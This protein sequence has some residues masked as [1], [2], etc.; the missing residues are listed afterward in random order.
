MPW[1]WPTASCCLHLHR[2]GM[3]ALMRCHRRHRCAALAVVAVV[4]M[5]WQ[6]PLVSRRH[7]LR[8]ASK[9]TLSPSG[10]C[11][12]RVVVV[13]PPHLCCAGVDVLMRCRRHR[14][15]VALVICVTLSSSPCLMP[16]VVVVPVSH[17]W[18][19]RPIKGTNVD[20]DVSSSE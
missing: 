4:V 14:V 18:H 9:D 15:A 13:S 20:T 6:W 19:L 11:R 2:T 10:H 17:H 1:H 3:D 5:P 16:V 12:R 7:C 8:R